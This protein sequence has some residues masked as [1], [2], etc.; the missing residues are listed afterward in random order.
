[1]LLFHDPIHVPFDSIHVKSAA[2]H[3]LVRLCPTWNGTHEMC[4]TG[5]VFSYEVC[6][7]QLLVAIVVLEGG[8]E[9]RWMDL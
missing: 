4:D 8:G 7:W 5:H 2:G 9:S 6:A 3:F 1:M